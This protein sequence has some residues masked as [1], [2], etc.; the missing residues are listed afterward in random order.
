MGGRGSSGK[1]KMGGGGRSVTQQNLKGEMIQTKESMGGK[2]KTITR[3]IY[4]NSGGEQHEYRFDS[5]QKAKKFA[6][7]NGIE[8]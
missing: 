8:I 1:S 3:L 5:I 6:K 4:R 7:A 2:Q